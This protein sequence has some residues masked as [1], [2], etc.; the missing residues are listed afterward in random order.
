MGSRGNTRD[1][2]SA[3]EA[4]IDLTSPSLGA[5]RRTSAVDTVRARIALAI[6]LGLVAPGER[7]PPKEETAVAFGVSGMTVVRA[8]RILQSSGV[9]VLRRGHSGGT[10]VSDAPPSGSVAA[11]AEYRAD[12]DHV[13][14]LIDERAALETG[15]AHLAATA[16][17]DSDLDGLRALVDRMQCASNWAEFRE[18]DTEFHDLLAA[19]AHSPAAANLHYRV[20]REL[21]EY[22]LPYPLEYLHGSNEHHAWIVSALEARDSAK[23]GTLANSHVRE[24][25]TSMYVGAWAT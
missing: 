23:A 14:R 24:L 13:R 20:S 12:I 19:S 21:Y 2:T 15:L 7:L 8:Y 1:L 25:H 17:D 11:V 9:L 22:F 10:F 4:A 3:E 18:A 16:R 5:I 6:E